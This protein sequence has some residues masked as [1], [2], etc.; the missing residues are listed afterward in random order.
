M[1]VYQRE[2]S[3]Y[4]YA[5]FQIDNR[6]ICRSTKATTRRKALA[7]EKQFRAEELAKLGAGGRQRLTV[8][9][10]FGRFWIEVGG[11][12]DDAKQRK[13]TERYIQQVLTTIDPAMPVEDVTDGEVNDF[14]QARIRAKA[15]Q[16]ATNRALAVWRQMHRRAHRVWKQKMQ[17]IDW[18]SFMVREKERKNHLEFDQVRILLDSLPD[19]LVLAVEWSVAAGTRRTATLGLE[20]SNVFVDRGYCIVRE[21]GR[22]ESRSGCRRS[23]STSSSAPRHSV[24]LNRGANADMPTSRAPS[25]LSSVRAIGASCGMPR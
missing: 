2:G 20:W 16:I 9:Q 13:D 6:R 8:D 18:R 4:Y 3:P 5:E 24:T 1:S 12:H 15:G 19:Y 21:K 14:V 11:K 17:P 25:A 10:A 23:W 7:V 22:A